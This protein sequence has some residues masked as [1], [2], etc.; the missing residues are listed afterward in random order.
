LFD[1]Q[2]LTQNGN[3]WFVS[4]LLLQKFPAPSFTVTTKITFILGQ[5]NEKSGLLILVKK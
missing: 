4:N 1:V 3:L 5:V 2:N